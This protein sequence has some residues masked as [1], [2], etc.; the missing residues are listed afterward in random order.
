MALLTALHS[1]VLESWVRATQ[2]LIFQKTLYIINS[3][4]LS[5]GVGSSDLSYTLI[6]MGSFIRMAHKQVRYCSLHRYRILT[7][8][9]RQYE[10]E[11]YQIMLLMSK[12]FTNKLLNT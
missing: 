9:F 8:V 7:E 2:V 6:F 10:G 3:I 1:T 12:K 11:Y 4:V 5:R